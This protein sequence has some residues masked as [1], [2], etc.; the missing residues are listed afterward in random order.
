[1]SINQVKELFADRRMVIA[2]KHGKEQVLKP[3]LEE[4]F[5]VNC[6][7]AKGLD[8]DLLGTFSGEV[9]RTLDPLHP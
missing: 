4:A 3:L 9:E 6:I 5:E 8:P 1:M 7:L 2:T